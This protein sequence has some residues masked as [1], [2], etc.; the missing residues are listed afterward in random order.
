MLSPWDWEDMAR[1]GFFNQIGYAFATAPALDARCFDITEL[2]RPKL[3]DV[4]LHT[5]LRKRRSAMTFRRGLLPLE[6]LSA[7]L[8]FSCGLNGSLRVGGTRRQPLH[9]CPSPGALY[10]LIPIVE[11]RS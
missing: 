10:P 2:P 9:F 3:P 7:I 5:A 11:V 8:H 4:R 1:I 6:S